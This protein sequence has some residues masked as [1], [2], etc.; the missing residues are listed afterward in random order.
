MRPKELLTVKVF[1]PY[2]LI[3]NANYLKVS[4][5]RRMLAKKKKTSIDILCILQRRESII[6]RRYINLRHVRWIAVVLA[7][8]TRKRL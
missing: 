1:S 6:P 5:T 4:L 8:S 7:T 3:G 2:G